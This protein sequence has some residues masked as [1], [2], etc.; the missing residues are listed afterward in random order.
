MRPQNH[1]FLTYLLALAV[2][3][4]GAAAAAEAVPGALYI[5]PM[6]P[7]VDQDHPGSCPSCGMALEVAGAA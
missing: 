3:L 4:P 6:C 1:I 2:F 5:C 7:E